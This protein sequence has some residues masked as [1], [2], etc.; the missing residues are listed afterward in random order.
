MVH[1]QFISYGPAIIEKSVC[2]G[3]QFIFPCYRNIMMKRHIS[4]VWE[5]CS[6]IYTV[7]D[8]KKPIDFK[9]LTYIRQHGKCS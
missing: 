1:H 2:A 3:L 8:F 7:I 4:N 5:L 9:Q 6:Y